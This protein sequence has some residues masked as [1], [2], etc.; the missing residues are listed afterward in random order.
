MTRRTGET[1]QLLDEVQ[2]LKQLDS[3]ERAALAQVCRIRCVPRGAVIFE[4]GSPPEGIFVIVSGRVRVV[5]TAPDGREQVLH[6]EGAGATLAEVPAFDGQGYVGTAIATE[7]TVF[8]MVPRAMLL[9]VLESSSSAISVIA[10][11]AARLRKVAGVAA[12][13][14]FKPIIDRLAA[15]LLREHERTRRLTVTLPETRDELG[16][17]IGTVREQASRALSQLNRSGAIEVRGR[18]V[19]IKNLRQLR[20]FAESDDD[21]TARHLARIATPTPTSSP[22]AHQPSGSHPTATATPLDRAVPDLSNKRI[23]LP[24]EDDS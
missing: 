22:A 8:L 18:R 19:A 11:L 21:S 17:H 14:S 7:D 4:A 16:S 10:V 5:R 1:E 20:A 12:D 24:G 23:V 3:A 6:E 9:K 2:Y 13:L 15:Y